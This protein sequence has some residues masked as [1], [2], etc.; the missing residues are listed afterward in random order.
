MAGPVK[1]TE[2]LNFLK[3]AVYL[4]LIDVRSPAEFNSGHIPGAYNIPL[5]DNK[6]R[7][8]VGIKYKKEGRTRAIL[9][10]LELTGPA[11]VSKLEQGLKLA[12]NK[13]LLVYCWRGGMRSEAMAWLFSLGDIQPEL[14]EGGYKSYRHY[15]LESLA[16]KRKM[17]VLGGLTGSGKTD[18]L[19]Y[20]K[21]FGHEVIDLE[22]LA[23]HKGSA[24]GSLGQSPQP[25]SEHFANLLYHELDETNKAKPLWIED[26]SKNIGAVFIPDYFYFNMQESPLIALV[27]DIRTRLPRLIEEYSGYPK[28]Y[29]KASVMKIS[30]RLGGENTKESID[31]LE[32]NDFAGAI[33]IILGYYDKAYL[34]SLKKR[35]GKNIHY[36]ETDTDDIAINASKVL[37]L[38]DRLC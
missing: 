5:F 22:G 21:T 34:F 27:M 26:E 15:I 2:I 19:R 10:G 6:E 17:I 3:M 32:R 29:L 35:S 31:A 7:E 18:I 9:K 38:A 28:E 24:F 20:I 25:S 8:S 37:D 4:P 36:I 11:L 1:K 23:N 33:E 13:K 16:E 14:L 12:Q 30:R